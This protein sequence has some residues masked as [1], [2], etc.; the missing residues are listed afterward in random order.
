MI[1]INAPASKSYLQRV[2][3]ISTL[4]SGKTTVNNISWCNDSLAV[5]KIVEQLGAKITETENAITIN[6]EKLQINNPYFNVGES[7]LALRM[8]SSILSLFNQEK[9]I[10]AQGSLLNRPIEEIINALQ[11]S[12]I[13]ISTQQGKTPLT[14]KGTL[15]AGNYI[16]D[17]SQSSQILTGLLIT[18]PLLKENS[19]I[20]AINLKSKPYIDLTIEIMKLF[21]V[22]IENNNY[23]KFIINGNQKYI[24][25][26]IN[27]EGDWSGAAYFLVY[28][29]VKN[30]IEIKN[31]D[32]NSKQADKQIIDALKSAGALVTISKNSVIVEK[33]QLNSFNFDASNCPDLF[34]PLVCLASQ[35]NGIST[36]KGT[37]RLIHKESNR[38]E[39]LKTEF[40]KIGLQISVND[41]VMTITPAK[42]K[43][44]T[45]NSNNDHRIA[46]VAGLMNL[47][48]KNG[49]INIENK[50]AI[51]KSY[52]NYFND[53]LNNKL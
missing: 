19:I 45:I 8:F 2:L 34:P 38:A 15:K 29:A 27:I 11:Q 28:G 50:E 46:M 39:V 47:F 52:P 35:C 14:L 36:I 23:E 7:G 43:A 37:N 42:L 48:C 16:I 25:T 33:N 5:K 1:Q 26:N 10:Y 9:T 44:G 6:N 24:S 3:A 22:S 18:L 31:L 13:K 40:N 32:Y 41:N 17:G 49:T 12:E 30:K 51:N 53:I 20:D 4:A 21:G